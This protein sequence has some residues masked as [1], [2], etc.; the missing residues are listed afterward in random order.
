MSEFGLCACGCG[1]TTPIAKKTDARKGYRKGDHTKYCPG[2]VQ[3][4]QG[5]AVQ[6]VQALTI[7]GELTES[8]IANL[9]EGDY[10]EGARVVD[11]RA[12]AIEKQTRRS[13]VEL[14]LIC[15]TMDRTGWWAKL[16]DPV[17]GVTFHSW[18]DWATSALNVARSSAFAAKKVIE[19]TKGTPLDDLRDMTRGN[20]QQF[21]R[22]SSKVQ[23]DPE[24][25]EKAKTLTEEKFVEAVHKSA[26]DQHLSK[27]PALIVNLEKSD[28]ENF[29][30]AVEAAKWAYEVESRNDAIASIIAYFLDGLCERE[31]YIKQ[32]NRDAFAAA[33]KR[34]AA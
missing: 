15:H 12:R 10:E 24:I 7:P 21:A 11:A 22:L 1:Q 31:G 34:A 17:T 16:A 25:L 23:A 26:P 8:D 32:T 14:G 9:E 27:A 3:R 33:S 6:V 18:E 30:E 13:F 20:L 5:H 29:D 4:T 19:A 28:R 2:H